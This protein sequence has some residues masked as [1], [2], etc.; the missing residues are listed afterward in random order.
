MK[1]TRKCNFKKSN[2]CRG[3]N[4]ANSILTIFSKNCALPQRNASEFG[5]CLKEAVSCSVKG[6]RHHFFYGAF[7]E[8]CFHPIANIILSLEVQIARLASGI[9]HF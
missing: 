4:S 9:L 1:F 5:Y 7:S 2:R 8:I 3:E 6:S